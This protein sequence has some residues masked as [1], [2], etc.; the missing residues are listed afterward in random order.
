MTQEQIDQLV[1]MAPHI[2]HTLNWMVTDARKRND[3]TKPGDY[4]DDLQIA[5]LC[6]DFMKEIV[7]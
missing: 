5:M 2:N 4:S 3:L 6:R 1:E 7:E